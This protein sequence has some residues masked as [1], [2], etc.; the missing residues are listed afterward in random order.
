MKRIKNN[1]WQSDSGNYYKVV[2]CGYRV[3]CSGCAFNNNGDNEQCRDCI[4]A[5]GEQN[6]FKKMTDEEVK[7]LMGKRK[8]IVKFQSHDENDIIEA[9]CANHACI[10]AQAKRIQAGETEVAVVKVI[11]ILPYI[12]KAGDYEITNDNGILSCTRH[13]EKWDRNLAGDN[14]VLAL[15]HKIEELEDKLS[16]IELSSR[17]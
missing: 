8:F 12:V 3:G 15:V 1:I 4:K 9:I 17:F 10:L 14:L 5:I 11:E 2:N 7:T 6:I 16:A 13:G